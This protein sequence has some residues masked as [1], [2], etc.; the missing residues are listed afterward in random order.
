MRRPPR[1]PGG[2]R[3]EA[4]ARPHSQGK[5]VPSEGWCSGYRMSWVALTLASLGWWSRQHR[6]GS[7]ESQV[8]PCG[9]E[10]CLSPGSYLDV[11]LPA[12]PSSPLFPCLLWF[13][14]PS[15]TASPFCSL[16][17]AGMCSP[18]LEKPQPDCGLLHDP[19][20]FPRVPAAFPRHLVSVAFNICCLLLLLFLELY[21]FSG[22]APSYRTFHGDERCPVQ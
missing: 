5:C 20:F 22:P 15:P 2:P 1:T 6:H 21:H 9:D 10:S 19:S 17:P 3:H 16:P 12:D 14:Q 18:P 8:Q 4:D 7:R 13:G 11:H